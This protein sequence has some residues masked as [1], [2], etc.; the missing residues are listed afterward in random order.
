VNGLA[1]PDA[2]AAELGQGGVEVG[3]HQVKLV[4]SILARVHG[5]LARRQGEY[6][7]AAADVNRF[8]TEDV[9]KEGPVGCDV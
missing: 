5:E 6:Q 3:A 2:F 1:D 9:A 4:G 8:E 7:P